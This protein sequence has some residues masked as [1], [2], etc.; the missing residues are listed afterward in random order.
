MSSWVQFWNWGS[1]SVSWFSFGLMAQGKP[2]FMG[3]GFGIGF[4]FVQGKQPW[5]RERM[6]W[7]DG[8][9]VVDLVGEVRV[10]E[11]VGLG[12]IC[13][14]FILFFFWLLFMVMADLASGGD[15]G[16][17]WWMCY[18]W[19]WMWIFFFFSLLLFVVVVD[20]AGGGDGGWM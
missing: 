9:A 14:G 19:M 3:F 12:L 2:G 8:G 7:V 4:G 17:M 5:L 10:V 11:V 6:W 16:W 18:G 1:K 15:G 13:G 20:L